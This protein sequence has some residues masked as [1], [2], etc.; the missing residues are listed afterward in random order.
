MPGELILGN[1]AIIAESPS[2]TAQWLSFSDKVWAAISEK[3]NP[4]AVVYCY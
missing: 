3:T 1:L 4:G 2:S